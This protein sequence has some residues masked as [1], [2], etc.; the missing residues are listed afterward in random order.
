MP[1]EYCQQNSRT[2]HNK[3]IEWEKVIRHRVMSR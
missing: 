1:E 2:M 3:L